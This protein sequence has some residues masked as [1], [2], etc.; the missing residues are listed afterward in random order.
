VRHRQ[1]R[2]TVN[3]P[4]SKPKPKDFDLQPNSPGVPLNGPYPC[5]SC[6]SMDYYLFTDPEGRKA[7]LAY[8]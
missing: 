6:K 2:R 7:E 5:N 3:R 4:Q 8:P 1:S